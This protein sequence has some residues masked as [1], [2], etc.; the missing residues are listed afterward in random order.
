M[1]EVAVGIPVPKWLVEIMVQ[2]IGV[3]E[4]EKILPR[5]AVISTEDAEANGMVDKSVGSNEEL[6]REVTARFEK[7]LF[8]ISEAPQVETFR[9]L[10]EDF[11]KRLKTLQEDDMKNLWK[12]L[13]DDRFREGVKHY[14]AKL[15]SKQKP[16]K[17]N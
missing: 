17:S 2:L 8:G 12:Y 9:Y 7:M 1:N 10:R 5:G 11:G 6:G 4:A 16:S 15:S 3:Q 14:L 13:G